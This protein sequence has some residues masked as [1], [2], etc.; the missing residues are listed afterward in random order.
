MA[1]KKLLDENSLL[2]I[3]KYIDDYG[4]KVDD[5]QINSTSIINDKV[6]NLAAEGSYN[7]STNKIATQ[8]TITNAIN[9]LDVSDLVANPTSGSAG[10]AGRTL[11]TLLE[12]N[13]KIQATFQDIQLASTAKVTGLDTALAGKVPT[14]RTIAGVDLADNITKEEMITALGLS[15]AITYIGEATTTKPTTGSYVQTSITIGG[16]ATTLYV[17]MSDHGGNSEEAA[18][19]GQVFTYGNKEYICTTAGTHTANA[20]SEFG[21][22]GSYALKTIT[23][24]GTGALGG[25]GTLEQPRTIT[26]NELNTSGAQATAKV[27]KQTL[28]KYGHVLSATEATYSDVGAAA[29]GHTHSLSIAQDSSGS[30][31]DVSLLANTKYDL[32]L[33]ND[34]KVVFKTPQDLNFYPTSFSWSNGTT[35][36]P[37]GSL[38]GSGMSS[39]TFGAI[40]SASDTIS[41]V[42][43][44]GAQSFAGVKT[45]VAN[46]IID[47][48]S[49]T[50][51]MAQ[52][53]FKSKY[54][55][56]STAGATW[57]LQGKDDGGSSQTAKTYD[58]ELPN[59]S[60]VLQLTKNDKYHTTGSWGGT[61]NITYT[62]TA[63]G[64]AGALAFTLPVADGSNYG[65]VSTTTQTF[66]GAKTFNGN[67][68]LGLNGA[69]HSSYELIFEGEAG[70]GNRTN[71]H[72]SGPM[73]SSSST[74]DY[75]LDLPAQ[76]TSSAHATLATTSDVDTV[77]TN[78]STH[79]SNTGIHV[80][81][82]KKTEW[83]AKLKDVKVTEVTSAT[84]G[85]GYQKLQKSSNGTDYT[86]IVSCLSYN[87]A[88]AILTASA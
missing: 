44:I 86:D 41:G 49:T 55:S 54:Y 18:V 43:T 69:Q 40:P 32:R 2:A 6:A 20:F 51:R 12:V 48:T 66:A 4:G 88:W 60:G 28:D 23:I 16:T 3:K 47:G 36:G 30:T 63:N 80:T 75:Y 25:G 70:S 79:T 5:V 11:A 53:S 81:S 39:V 19:L 33:D 84:E 8:S 7:A 27:W 14:S 50:S 45:F 15:Q 62:A 31:V 83:D 74:V 82:A 61:N 78:L 76:G 58:I 59:E 37:T 1:V 73:T 22:E 10:G 87:E 71:Y 57:N 85:A 64:G 21:D 13:G 29:S 17:S 56:Q 72:L 35:S 68:T 52:L 24:T 46:P 65:I 9:A 26:H 67:V 38:T 42:V 34:I 77:A